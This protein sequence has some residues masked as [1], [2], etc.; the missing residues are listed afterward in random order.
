MFEEYKN[1]MKRKGK[2]LSDALRYNS[3]VVVNATWMQST[4]YR[5]VI[6]K[7]IESGLPVFDEDTDEILDA[8]FEQKSKYNIP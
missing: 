5:P 4:S 3:E 1:R 2:Y 7:R 8:H 6:V